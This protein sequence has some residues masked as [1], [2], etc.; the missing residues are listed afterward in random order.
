[1]AASDIVVHL[2]DC[3]GAPPP[4]SYRSAFLRA[5]ESGLLSR[6][7]SRSLAL[8]AGLRN[9]PLHEYEEIDY[10]LSPE[11]PGHCGRHDPLHRGM[12]PVRCVTA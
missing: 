2:L 6:E 3:R 10:P 12:P 1:M 4:V 8:G 9:I 11:P 5:G 7:L